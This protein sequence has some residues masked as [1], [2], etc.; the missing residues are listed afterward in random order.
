M[1][2]QQ[3]LPKEAEPC[4]L[5]AT[6]ANLPIGQTRTGVNHATYEHYPVNSGFHSIFI[7]G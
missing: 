6:D 3:V 2:V 4:F 7:R 1:L 5:E